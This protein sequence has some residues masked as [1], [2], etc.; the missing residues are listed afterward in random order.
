M[1][2][3]HKNSSLKRALDTKKVEFNAQLYDIE[4][5]FKHFKKLYKGDLA[6]S[7]WINPGDVFIKQALTRAVT[8]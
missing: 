8:A 5:A 7:K 2:T 1:T 4:K 6:N 3:D